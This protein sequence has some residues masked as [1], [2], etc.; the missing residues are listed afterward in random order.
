VAQ[1]LTWLSGQLPYREVC[2]VLER[3]VHINVSASTVWR[4]V[5]SR[6]EALRVAEAPQEVGAVVFEGGPADGVRREGSA[7]RL[8]CSLD[9]G[10]VHI[11]DEGWKELKV[12]VIFEVASQEGVDVR[13][14]KCVEVGHAL[15]NSYVAHLGGPE[16]FGAMLWKEAHRRRWEEAEATVGIGDGAVWIWNLIDTHFYD[17][18]QVVDWYHGTQHLAAAAQSLH[19]DESEAKRWYEKWKMKLYQGQAAQIAEY[20]TQAAAQ[21]TASQ[22]SNAATLQTEAGYFS[23]HQRRMQ[24]MQMREEGWPIG[25]GT[26]ESGCKQFKHRFAGPGMRWSRAGAEHLIPVRAAVMSQRF[27]SV[28]KRVFNSPK[29]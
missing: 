28:W 25:S 11:R 26:V 7:E 17:S 16:T 9:G 2:A 8:G 24:Y 15:N 19:E 20:L 4:E 13:S 1:V 22:P 14:K 6:G 21:R 5:Q 23:T 29:N 27:D 10:M 12:G 18:K 3:V